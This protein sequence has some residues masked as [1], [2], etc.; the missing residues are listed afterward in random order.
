MPVQELIEEPVQELKQVFKSTPISAPT[1]TENFL[2][3][4][5]E[6]CKQIIFQRKQKKLEKLF[7]FIQAKKKITN[8]DVCKFLRVSQATATRY[9]DS[10]E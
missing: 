1:Q 9:L 3:N 4:I 7:Y 10:L 8:A 5:L 6:K 2:K